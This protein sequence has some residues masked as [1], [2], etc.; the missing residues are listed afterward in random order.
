MMLE[1]EGYRVLEAENGLG[2][3]DMARRDRPDAILMDMSLPIMDGYEAT[4]RI[5]EEP[6]LASVPIIACT[7]HNRWEWRGKA[8]VAGCTDF[9]TKPLEPAALMTMLLRYLH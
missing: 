9:L 8:I 5:R 3:L 4:K 1:L 7:A 6:G 2:A